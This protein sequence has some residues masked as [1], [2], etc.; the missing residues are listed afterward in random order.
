MNVIDVGVEKV[1][2]FNA[3]ITFSNKRL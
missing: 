2:E 3:N 1:L